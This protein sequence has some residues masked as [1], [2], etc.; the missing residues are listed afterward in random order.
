MKTTLALFFLFFH[1]VNTFA[2]PKIE[3]ANNTLIT[4]IKQFHQ[5]LITKNSNT[6]NQHTDKAL[7]YGHSNGWVQ[8]KQELINDLVTEKIT[9]QSIQ[10]DS[11]VVHINAGVANIRFNGAYTATMQ[12]AT[13]TYQLKVLEVWV[14]RAKHWKLFAR[15]AIKY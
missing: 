8:S 5:A 3:Q 13:Y 2:Q 9:Y 7:S 11:I 4:T 1:F 6:I 10:E 12:N 14:M 15:Q